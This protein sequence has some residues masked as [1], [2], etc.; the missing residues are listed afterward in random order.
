MI[1]I[2]FTLGLAFGSDL[3]QICKDYQ[4]KKITYE[5]AQKKLNDVSEDM[6]AYEIT[7]DELCEQDS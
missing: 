2:V 7:V 3:D 1:G 4:D 5:E 6:G